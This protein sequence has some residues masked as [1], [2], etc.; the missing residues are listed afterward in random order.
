MVEPVSEGRLCLQ[1][2]TSG[3]SRIITLRIL[4]RDFFNSF[5]RPNLLMCIDLLNEWNMSVKD[6]LLN[7]WN[8]SVKDDL[9]NEW[10]IS[11]KDAIK[12]K[13]SQTGS[14]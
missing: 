4:K 1:K 7:K 13:L 2:A 12:Q 11:V 9:L 14:P 6:D 8:M 5:G 10:N 3:E